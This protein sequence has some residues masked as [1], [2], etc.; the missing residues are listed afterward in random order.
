MAALNMLVTN[1]MKQQLKNYSIQ[2]IKEIIPVVAGILIA[3]FIDNWN[4][5][6][7]DAAYIEQVFSSINS[8]LAET[9]NAIKENVPEQQALIDALA[10]KNATIADIIR[11]SGGINIPSIKLSTW[12]A[13]SNAKID[14][15]SYKK[16][17]SLSTIE[18][19]KELLK[20]K[21]EYLMGF[22]YSNL[23][24]TDSN[25]KE[26]FKLLLQD[27]IQTEKT[28]LRYIEEFEKE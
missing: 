21:T 23:Y 18:E 26:V 16:M 2:F 19:Y 4:A 11:K 22:L 3:L 15:V 5:Q 12:K 27:I 1:F 6:R 20:S 8:E 14:L 7:K 9:K 24:E 13:V 10:N 25:K 28:T 17:T